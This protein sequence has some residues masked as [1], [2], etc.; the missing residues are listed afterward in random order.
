MRKIKIALVGCGRIAKQ[1]LKAIN[2]LNKKVELIYVFSRDLKKAKK[3]GEQ[4]N[5]KRYTNNINEVITSKEIDLV[6]I[7]TPNNTHYELS[8]LF[9]KNNKHVF[10]EK[11]LTNTYLEAEELINLAKKNKVILRVGYICRYFESH[12]IIKNNIKQIG[13]LR[14]II[15]IRTKNKKIIDWWLNEE[16]FLLLFQGSHSIDLINWLVRIRCDEV[17]ASLGYINKKFK[18]ET[19]F[20]LELKFKNNLTATIMHSFFSGE[21]INYLTIFGDK[22]VMEVKDF[23][24][25]YLN[26][27]LIFKTNK[28]YVEK[29]FQEQINDLIKIIKSKKYSDEYVNNL[30]LTQKIM[31]AGYMSKGNKIL[32]ENL[33][34]VRT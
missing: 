9:I 22:G 20:N 26:G 31:E 25:V 34:K 10:V 11:P 5:S 27:N 21:S 1:H 7:T 30:L 16:R 15:N 17:N 28:D 2:K 19:L 29:A 3:Y 6:I 24:K 18:G 14:K 13:Q 33:N 4:Y 32:L 8:K 23:S 12:K